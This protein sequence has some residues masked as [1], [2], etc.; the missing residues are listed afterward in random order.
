MDLS[1]S[2][3]FDTDSSI[4]QISS[5]EDFPS[6]HCNYC[7]TSGTDSI[8]FC[9]TC[10]KL[11]CSTPLKAGSH[12]TW[13]LD[14]KKHTS[15]S[16]HPRSFYHQGLFK[17]DNCHTHNITKLC[18]V[19]S[20]V[21]LCRECAIDV[22][23]NDLNT[24]IEEL[25]SNGNPLSL[26]FGESSWEEIRNITNKRK[27]DVIEFEHYNRTGQHPG[28]DEILRN[29]QLRYND[30][31]DYK[32]MYEKLLIIDMN[33]GMIQTKT[34]YM[35]NVKIYFTDRIG[36]FD[37]DLM[38][39]TLKLIVGSAITIFSR[40]NNKLTQ[41]SDA[42]VIEIN[43]LTKRIKIKIDK[44]STQLND[45]GSF[46][47]KI[48]FIPV[49]YER[50]LDGLDEF[51]NADERLKNIILGISNQISDSDIDHSLI[52]TQPIDWVAPELS[53][54]N[55]YQLLALKEALRKNL[56]LI[57]GPPGTGKTQSTAV[58]VWKLFNLLNL[59]KYEKILVTSKSNV[60][61]DNL[62]ERIH[63]TGIRVIKVASRL[64]EN[65]KSS[66]NIV[67]DNSL[68]VVLREYVHTNYPEISDLFDM[69]FL[70]NERLETNQHVELMKIVE[71]SIKK[72]LKKTH[73]ICC[74]NIVSADNRLYPFSFPYVVMDEASQLIEPET[75]LPIIKD[76]KHLVL[77]GDHMQLGPL[78]MCRATQA[79]GLA[80]SLM[81]RLI[82]LGIQ[83]K[84]LKY[85]YRMHPCISEFP[86]LFFYH[87][88]LS[89]GI[90]SEQRPVIR[91]FWPNDIPNIFLHNVFN[92]ASTGSNS[93]SNV[94]EAFEVLKVIKKLKEKGISY[95]QIAILTPYE[96]QK[97]TIISVTL[98]K[99]IFIKVMNID[100]FQGNEEDYIVF[101]TVRSNVDHNIGFL[102]NFR[103]LNVAI[104]RAKYGMVI[105]GDCITL[106][107][108]DLWGHLINHYSSR[109][110]IYSGNFGHLRLYTE[111]PPY[112]PEYRFDDHFPYSDQFNF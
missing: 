21:I 106:G 25:I 72:I 78:T 83:P 68:H 100:E 69:N 13:H 56:T 112:P 57:Q 79:A 62:L 30:V 12:F 60:A 64:R 2:E 87:G 75:L 91:D 44:R 17:C 38:N 32:T 95:D 82:H 39:S 34:K 35:K 7:N 14:I 102:Q 88:R 51:R 48:K 98:K 103:R 28:N 73:V 19:N 4:S 40:I 65:I 9:H 76:C 67:E 18:L 5:L 77:F 42:V 92:E 41:I 24:C 84:L 11:F 10:S 71:R 33:D 110:M 74:T 53:P 107:K 66:S 63:R 55:N 49:P 85:Q 105:L 96:A 111:D 3:T 108:Y 81:I 27:R 22:K 43:N 8:L 15:W 90:S 61:V 59:T 31:E 99:K 70:Y 50:M 109:N 86:R 58:Y 80:R 97:K 1:D 37:Y 46:T 6:G 16:S 45:Q 36:V 23:L 94:N 47:L 29:I 26:V 54:L 20:S 52:D 101:S 104:T 89:D 93:V